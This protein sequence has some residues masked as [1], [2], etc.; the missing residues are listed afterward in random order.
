MERL[1]SK[2]A[3]TKFWRKAKYTKSVVMEYPGPASA[4]R[5]F[6]L[7]ARIK[8]SEIAIQYGT[9]TLTNL[10]LAQTSHETDFA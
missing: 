5:S 6:E 2:K 7:R 3:G 4:A 1:R 10:L 9:T 8:V